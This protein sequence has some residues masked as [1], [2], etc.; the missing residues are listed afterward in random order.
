MALTIEQLEA[1]RETALL[2]MSEPEHIEAFGRSVTNRNQ[3]DLLGTIHQLDAEIARLQSP[4]GRT[5]V[6]QTKRGIE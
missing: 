3:R 2:A 4:Q 1:E 6:I 5:F